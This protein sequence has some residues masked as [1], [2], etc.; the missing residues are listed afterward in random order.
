MTQKIADDFSFIAQRQRELFGEKVDSGRGSGG[1][2]LDATIANSPAPTHAGETP[3]LRKFALQ[4]QL[5]KKAGET[6]DEFWHR[7][8]SLSKP[9]V[10]PDGRRLGPAY[11]SMKTGNIVRKAIGLEDNA[12]LLTSKP[13]LDVLF[14]L[15]MCEH[16]V[17]DI[18]DS[19]VVCT[20]GVSARFRGGAFGKI[21]VAYDD[22]K[23]A[24]LPCG[25]VAKTGGIEMRTCPTAKALMEGKTQENQVP[26]L[27]TGW[28]E[29]E[30]FDSKTPVDKM[31]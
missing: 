25:N 21:T 16:P 18:N 27:K 17:D 14:V 13:G 23:Q 4:L 11:R 24:D 22:E 15:M 29:K 30:S 2:I 8:D 12:S 9:T 7:V 26:G 3:E 6:I 28:G 1:P 20:P 5:K 19:V 31:G 10:A